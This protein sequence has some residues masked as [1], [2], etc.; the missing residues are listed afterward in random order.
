M[1]HNSCMIKLLAVVLVL[2]PD[3]WGLTDPPVG[4]HRLMGPDIDKDKTYS[5]YRVKDFF[6]KGASDER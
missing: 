6:S 3:T 4:F 1:G 5:Y 2:G